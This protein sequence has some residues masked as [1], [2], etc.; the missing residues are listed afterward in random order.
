MKTWPD[1]SVSAWFYADMQEA[2]NGHGY[3]WIIEDGNKVKTGSICSTRTGKIVSI[4][5]LK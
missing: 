4:M 3:E 2:T 5:F 1:N